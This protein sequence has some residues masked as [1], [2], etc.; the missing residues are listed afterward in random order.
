VAGMESP[1]T[2]RVYAIRLRAYLSFANGQLPSRSQVQAFLLHLRATGMGASGINQSLSA[3]KKLVE[4]LGERSLL[5]RAT[6]ASILSLKRERQDGVRVGKWLD[7]DQ[8]RDFLDLPLSLRDRA[9][10]A[11]MVGCGLRREELASLT[12]DKFQV[13]WGRWCFVDIKGKGGKVRTVAVPDWAA[14]KLVQFQKQSDSDPKLCSL[15]SEHSVTSYGAS[16]RIFGLTASGIWFLV[17]KYAKMLDL[18]LAPHDLRRTFA[19]LSEDGGAE[20]RQI[21]AEMGHSS[22]QTTERYLGQLRG[23]KAGKAA[24]DFIK[25]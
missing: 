20:I 23:L 4:E 13:R 1:N 3:V 9:L 22:I 15:A 21:Q 2:R 14:D 17:K 8:A 7:L 10:L 19:A 6:V 5:D 18:T 12:W 11:V 25:L 16:R 24:G